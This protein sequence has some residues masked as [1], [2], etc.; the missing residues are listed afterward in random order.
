[1][2]KTNRIAAMALC[3]FAGTLACG[4]WIGSRL[5]TPGLKPPTQSGEFSNGISL[6]ITDDGEVW[7][8]SSSQGAM[9]DALLPENLVP[10]S[11]GT[12]VSTPDESEDLQFFPQTLQDSEESA[13]QTASSQSNLQPPAAPLSKAERELWKAELSNLRPAEAQEILRLREQLGPI[14]SETL[15]FPTF[16]SMAETSSTPETSSK[17]DTTPAS[18]D[19]GDVAPSAGSSRQPAGSTAGSPPKLFPVPAELARAD[20]IPVVAPQSI[21]DVTSA[22]IAAEMSPELELFR[23]ELFRVSHINRANVLT[24]GFKRLEIVVL[25]IPPHGA[26]PAQANDAERANDAEQA[27]PGLVWDLRLNLTQGDAIQTGNPRDLMIRG[28]G[29]FPLADGDQKLFTRAGLLVVQDDRTV[30]LRTS[31]GFLPF[32]PETKLPEDSSLELVVESGAFLQAIDERLRRHLTL[33]IDR[34]EREVVARPDAVL[35]PVVRFPNPAALQ[36]RTDG[37]YEATPDSGA[38]KPALQIPATL[39]SAGMLEASNSQSGSESESAISDLLNLL[40]FNEQYH[41]T[42]R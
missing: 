2:S 8:T 25:K 6:R 10:G 12:S 14:A 7:Q 30:G 9:P 20:G 41:R 28:E 29:W 36:F 26:L 21:V 34:S 31:R 16:P 18:D 27:S 23:Q 3:G 32:S 5:A 35:I 38:P 37:L 39:I 33:K 13:N 24:V 19:S 1:M 17:S 40:H 22:Q 15:G 11:G 4:V 42:P